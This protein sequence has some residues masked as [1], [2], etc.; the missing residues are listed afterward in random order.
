[1]KIKKEI[2]IIFLILLFFGC[3][4]RNVN[5]YIQQIFEP[6]HGPIYIPAGEFIMGSDSGKPNESPAH[7]V[8]LDSYY[9][10]ENLVTNEEY[11]KFWE[12]P[13]GGNKYYYTPR[14]F[15]NNSWPQ[16]ASR[17]PRHP[18]IGISWSMASKY[19]E[20]AGKRLPTEAEWE[21]AAKG[22]TQRKYPWGDTPP[23]YDDKFRANFNIIDFESNFPKDGFSSTSPV[24]YYNGINLKTARGRSP[25]ELNDMAGNVWEWVRDWYSPDYYKYSPYENPKGPEYDYSDGTKVIRGGSWKNSSEELVTTFRMQKP[26]DYRENDIGFRCAKSAQ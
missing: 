14:S 17:K 3:N 12:D 4:N 21:K 7:I 20:W 18:V 2:F 22:V 15:T 23:D 16:R 1:M 25:Y 5:F 8:Y 19:A 11:L 9:I 24:G 26:F 6:D 10:D 13:K